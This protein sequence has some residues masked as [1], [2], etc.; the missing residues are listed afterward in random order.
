MRKDLRLPTRC[1]A[2]AVLAVPVFGSFYPPESYLLGRIGSET[3]FSQTR[4]TPAL[5]TLSLLLS[6]GLLAVASRRAK[7]AIYL[8]LALFLG[9]LLFSTLWALEPT[10]AAKRAIRVVP[11]VLMGLVLGSVSERQFRQIMVPAV[12]L[13]LGIGACMAVLVPDLGRSPGILIYE[14]AW[15]GLQ[16]HKNSLGFLSSASLVVLFANRLKIGPMAGPLVILAALMMLL[17]QSAT[18]LLSAIAAI[19]ALGVGR[20]ANR[21]P[22]DLR[23]ALYFGLVCLIA[24]ICAVVMSSG[25]WAFDLLGRDATFTGR[26]TIWPQVLGLISQRPF[27]GFGYYFWGTSSPERTMI[28]ASEGYEVLHSHNAF[29][30]VAL[31]SGL[32]AASLLIVTL[33][34]IIRAALF[35]DPNDC[36]APLRL[37]LAVLLAVAGMTEA[38][39]SEPGTQGV[40]WLTLLATWNKKRPQKLSVRRNLETSQAL[41]RHVASFSPR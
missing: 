7:V 41:E 11:S 3:D 40:F 10:E 17:S 23:F 8:P 28:W 20:V 18:A 5:V 2:I 12:A 33:L 4:F 6:S 16:M 19:A 14:N 22:Y 31:Q 39:F 1:L 13:S 9:I 26:T 38:I 27:G 36:Q 30:D 35:A 29:L 37:S 34:A 25:E 21:G 15:R 24:L 32:P